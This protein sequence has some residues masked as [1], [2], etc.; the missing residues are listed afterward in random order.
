MK[1]KGVPKH[2]DNSSL[3]NISSTDP[4][5]LT[6]N[7]TL[8]PEVLKRNGYRT[9]LI[10]KWHLGH[11]NKKYLPLSRGFDTHYGFWQGA[12]D[13]YTKVMSVVLFK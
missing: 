13:Y 2:I 11:C 4:T 1:F 5:G 8:L 7:V 3:H 10:G 6:L 9:H 12:E